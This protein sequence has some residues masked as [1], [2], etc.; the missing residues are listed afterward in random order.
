MFSMKTILGQ[1]VVAVSAAAVAAGLTWFLTRPSNEIVE[2]SITSTS[3]RADPSLQGLI[4]E[5]RIRIG[6]EEVPE[7]NVHTLQIGCVPGSY[8][9]QATFAV[10]FA[11]PTRT[12]GQ[13]VAQAP[14][15]AHTI[16]CKERRAT[17]SF[18]MLSGIVCEVEPMSGGD[19]YSVVV[20]TNTALQPSITLP[21][22]RVTLRRT[23]EALPTLDYPGLG[24]LTVLLMLMLVSLSV[25]SVALRRLKV[26]ASGNDSDEANGG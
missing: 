10:D 11:E 1:A 17:G 6:D 26:R 9:R 18:A 14:S 21:A 2:Y 13:V 25:F 15:S 22:L 8:L 12:F 20:A 3:L 7:L 23:G 16:V 19:S 4:P 24:Y 5:I